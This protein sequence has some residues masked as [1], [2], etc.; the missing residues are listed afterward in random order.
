M[1]CYECPPKVEPPLTGPP[2]AGRLSAGVKSLLA[3]TRACSR[4]RSLC[5]VLLGVPFPLGFYVVQLVAVPLAVYVVQLA[6]EKQFT[7]R[8]SASSLSL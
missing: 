5:S 3:L 7:D 2:P 6:A 8:H 4:S 1:Q